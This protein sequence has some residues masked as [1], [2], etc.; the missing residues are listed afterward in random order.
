MTDLTGRLLD[1]QYR[2]A[3][4]LGEGAMGQVYLA[5]AQ[6]GL[7]AVKVMRPELAG[8]ARFRERFLTEAHSLE[9]LRH[10]HIVSA[11]DHFIEDGCCCIVM[12]YI[13]GESLAGRL[14]RGK[15]MTVPEAMAI[16]LP[17]L[18]A[19][20]YAHTSGF[21][22][23]DV[24]PANILLDRHGTPKLCDFGIAREIGSRRLTA[25][26]RS[27]GTPEYMSPEQFKGSEI[28]HVSDVY[29]TGIVLFEMMTGRLPFAGN[30]YELAA[31]H[32]NETP[33]EPASLNRAVTPALNHIILKALRKPPKHRFQ[34][35][36]DFADK[37]RALPPGPP[38]ATGAG[39]REYEIYRHQLLR[40]QAVER[41]FSWPALVL[42]L[43]WMWRHGLYGRAASWCA[44][45]LALLLWSQAAP[46]MAGPAGLA[47]LFMV[48]LPAVRGNA[49][50]ARRLTHLGYRR[51]STVVA[52]TAEMALRHVDGSTG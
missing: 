34:G 15:P 30:Q 46:D 23:R 36:A 24:K 52:A 25:V 1:G 20:D 18:D 5:Q 38:V 48:L 16:I 41:G 26:G 9:T 7:V 37:L 51:T 19:L 10:P 42:S 39:T 4:L 11:C 27:V 49:W 50:R 3:R 47:A 43:I 33:A 22:H 12:E 35:C 21:I 6:H 29:S 44:A 32:A 31:R 17:V 8:D 2:I 40:P 45:Y 28:T 13:P 14:D